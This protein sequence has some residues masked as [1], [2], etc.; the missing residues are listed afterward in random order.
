MKL[1][2]STDRKS[3]NLA[4]PNGKTAKI[5]NAFGLPAGTEYSC[6]GATS[7]C[8]GVC[9]AGKLE[10]IFKGM[11][12]NMLHNWNLV[13]DA[14]I[15]DLVT[16]LDEVII[17]F[18]QA[19]DKW[20]ADKLFRIHHDG[21]FFSETYASAWA[22][23]MRRHPNVTFWAYTRSFHV[24][25]L[26]ADIPNFTL[27]LSVDAE[28]LDNAVQTFDAQPWVKLAALGK[29]FADARELLQAFGAKGAN[30]PELN[31]ALPLITVNGGACK[32]CGLCVFGRGNVA[33]SSSKK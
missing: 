6:P 27:Y 31:G 28:N 32:T 26:L 18:E 25:S 7:I 15:S 14:S 21:D 1:K 2:A 22:E 20:D 29:T 9:Y 4:S 16:M 13:K 10:R 33:F 5:K 3:A 17:D 30:C 23:V 12:E 24:V 11:R 8:D 19:C